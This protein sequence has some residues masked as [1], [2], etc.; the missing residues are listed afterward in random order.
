MTKP[1]LSD[2]PWL[3]VVNEVHALF[4]HPMMD[5]FA[6]TVNLAK[7]HFYIHSKLL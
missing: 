4:V 2:I 1:Q 6:A 7:L 3:V 5:L